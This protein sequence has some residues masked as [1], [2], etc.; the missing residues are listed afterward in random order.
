MNEEKAIEMI[1]SLLEKGGTMLATHHSCGAPLFRYRGEIVCPVCSFAEGSDSVQTERA[2]GE[3]HEEGALSREGD[4]GLSIDDKTAIPISASGKGMKEPVSDGSRRALSI[5]E[6]AS[7]ERVSS[8][9][10]RP[11]GLEEERRAALGGEDLELLQ[12][13]TALLNKLHALV[14][15]LEVEQDLIKIKLQ[16]ECIDIVLRSL[17]SLKEL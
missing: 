13:K 14:E 16:G 1:T 4:K 6:K 7:L 10:K 2:E 9:S 3:F 5:E 15:G 12:L 8:S 17:K 11:F